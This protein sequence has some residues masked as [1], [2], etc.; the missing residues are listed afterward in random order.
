MERRSKGDGGGE[1]HVGVSRVGVEVNV[2]N[3][4]IIGIVRV[5]VGVL[6]VV[7]VTGMK[8]M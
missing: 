3:V 5:K 6:E 7:G 8:G 4:R 2:I 1:R